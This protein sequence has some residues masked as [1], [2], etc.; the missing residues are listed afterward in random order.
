VSRLSW[1]VDILSHDSGIDRGVVFTEDKTRVWNGLVSVEEQASGPVEMI[2][3]FDGVCVGVTYESADYISAIS[4]LTYPDGLDEPSRVRGLSYRSD[5]G[6]GYRLHLVYNALLTPGPVTYSS[7]AKD[8]DP[9]AF[10]WTARGVPDRLPRARPSSH[11]ILE[12]T[13]GLKSLATVEDLLY[14]TATSK[15][16]LPS[17]EEV[18][19]IYGVESLFIVTYHGDG[20]YTVEGPDDMVVSD[21]DGGFQLVSPTVLS[22]EDGTFA[23]STY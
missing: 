17:P 16:Y 21:G 12:S 1:G 8:I 11:L 9:T 7:L 5:H 22:V 15:P 18:A 4:A 13:Q 14:G 3:Y 19:A 10:T 20:T 6:G 2:R 23:V